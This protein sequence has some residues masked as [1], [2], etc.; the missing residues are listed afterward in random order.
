MTS[1]QLHP[2]KAESFIPP[3]SPFPYETMEYP[4]YVVSTLITNKRTIL[5]I[6]TGGVSVLV[7]FLNP[8]LTLFSTL[9]I[10]AIVIFLTSG[11]IL[12]LIRG[13]EF[14]FFQNHVRVRRIF[15]AEIDIPYSEVITI[16]KGRFG[17]IKLR[18][19][20]RGEIKRISIS[21]S[22]KKPDPEEL[23]LWLKERIEAQKI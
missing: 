19:W 5:G 17:R 22:S 1:P 3:F 18:I 6:L 15:G 12:P 10:L 7:S 9:S 8:A 2:S 13:R 20:V 4:I 23:F 14:D 16:D 11:F 21:K